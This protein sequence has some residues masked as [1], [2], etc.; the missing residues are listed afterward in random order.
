[1]EEKIFTLPTVALRGMTILPGIVAHFDISR[2]KSLHAVQAAMTSNQKL[3]L[4]TQKN[5]N[6]EEPDREGLYEIGTVVE[7]KQVIKLQ[8]DIIR[9]LVEGSSRA[10]MYECTQREDFLEAK[11]QILEETIDEEKITEIE[12]EAMLQTGK[13][14]FCCRRFVFNGS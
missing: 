7:V 3:F 9:I 13:C 14:K 10:Q 11:I 5:E 2:K 4:I 1:M 12:H 6:Q 8:N